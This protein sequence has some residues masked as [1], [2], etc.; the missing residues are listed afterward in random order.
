MRHYHPSRLVFRKSCWYVSVT[1]PTQL[2]FG[3][4]RQARRSTGTS[5]K[6]QAQYLQHRLT[7]EIYAQFDNQLGRTD[8][9]F[10][11]LRP[12][13]E[14]HGVNTRQWY[15]DGFVLHTV[16]G[17]ETL[18]SRLTKG[19]VIQSDGTLQ[20]RLSVV[21]QWKA[22]NHV[23]LCAMVS[24]GLGHPIPAS[25]LA[26]LGPEDRAAVLARSK[27]LEL[28]SDL[29]VRM[30]KMLPEE[31][32]SNL[33]DSTRRLSPI[34]LDGDNPNIT[35]ASMNDPTLAHVIEDYLKTRSGKSRRSDR[36]H[37]NKWL[38]HKLGA[39]AL[40]RIDQY[41][42]YEFFEQQGEKLSKSSIGVLRAAVSNVFNWAVK[43]R[44]LNVSN[45]PVRGLD[46]TDVGHDGVEKR[47]FTHDELHRLFS[48]P[49]TPDDRVAL[50][51][52]ITT[53]MR[54]GELMQVHEISLHMG[55]RHFDLRHIPAAKTRGSRRLVPV[56]DGL[57]V[58]LPIETNQARLNSIIRK[59]WPNDPSLSLHSL[60]HSFKDLLRDLEVSKELND[61]I[62]GH[63]Q[64]DVAGEYG[65]GPSLAKR[66]EI[67]NRMRHPWLGEPMKP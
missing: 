40:I 7:E 5:D 61:Y 21:E 24:S 52:L 25:V 23:E 28:P 50:A 2:Q 46:L 55:I 41:D 6:R 59:E 30:A 26:L 44:G 45:N 37:L 10:E 39:K 42:L 22:S 47:P 29:M 63:G 31:M 15:Q 4:D 27:P 14:A 48:L 49:M 58:K 57:D 1:K 67:I 32:A 33:I 38:S 19:A 56:R 54:G 36:I 9:V 11:A 12:M 43:Q 60:R 13:L 17:S 66:L 51:I 62:T 34:V 64:G 35:S 16:K 18:T 8:P 53:G 3:S 65:I 20:Q